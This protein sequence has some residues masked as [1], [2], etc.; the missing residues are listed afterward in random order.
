[1]DSPDNSS[2][3]IDL[4]VE[5]S[6]FAALVQLIGPEEASAALESLLGAIKELVVEHSCPPG[7]GKRL[8]AS[9]HRLVFKAS[10]VGLPQLAKTLADLERRCNEGGDPSIGLNKIARDLPGLLRTISYAETSFRAPTAPS[11]KE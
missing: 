6:R 2:G 5:P 10:A 8:A 1:M 3:S 11:W 7:D 4:S 9:I